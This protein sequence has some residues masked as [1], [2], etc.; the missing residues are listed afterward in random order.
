MTVDK[1]LAI[2]GGGRL[3]EALLRGLLESE[4][5]SRQ[6]V[7][8]TVRTR[9]R[10]AELADRYSVTVTPGE[11]TAAAAGSEIVVLAVKPGVVADVLREI[12]SAMRPGQ[13]LISM[14]AAIPIQLLEDGLAAP[15]PVFRAMPNIAMTIR[16]SATALSA[17]DVASDADRAVVENIFRS[18]GT[19]HFVE[20]EAMHAVTALSGSGT[21]YGFLIADALADAG[22]KLGLA[23]DVALALAGQTLLGA[24]KLIE[25]SLLSPKELIDQVT[26]PGGTT[27]EGLK[28]LERHQVRAG[29]MAA[30]EAAARRSQS[31]TAELT[32]E[33]PPDS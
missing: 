4:T 7:R 26:T 25:T 29:L 9:R 5:V 33:A 14:A 2:L 21:A 16:Q 30:V 32:R 6:D 10:A 31:L 24:A 12:R 15:M 13:V 1:R 27:I 3:G 19:V 17:N 11:N 18:V 22:A 28:A 20:E 8:L 23:D